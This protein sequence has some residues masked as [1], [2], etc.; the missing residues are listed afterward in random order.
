MNI[1]ELNIVEH[2]AYEFMKF[3]SIRKELMEYTSRP[4][5]DRYSPIYTFTTENLDSYL[6]VLNIKDRSCLTVTS[7][8]DQIINLALL[9]ASNIDCFDTNRVAYYFTK[10][11]LSALQ[12]LKYEEFIEYFTSLHAIRPNSSV[13]LLENNNVFSLSLYKKIYDY[14]DEDVKLFFDMIYSNNNQDNIEV[15]KLFYNISDER[16]IYNNT[17]LR[18]KEHYYKARELVKKIVDKGINYNTLDVF[19]IT[20]LKNKYDIVLLSNIYDYIDSKKELYADF[21]TQDV[22]NIVNQ[23]GDILVNYQYGYRQRKNLKIVDNL[24]VHVDAFDNKYFNV[25]DI[26]ELSNHKFKLIGVPSIYRN[27]RDEGI[28]DCVYIYKNCRTI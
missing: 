16:A 25:S 28:E 6:N 13:M 10:L 19:D 27:S 11:K 20:S 9:G 22:T 8:G 18:D 7:S 1:S 24:A 15:K 23:D 21:V 17:Y 2:D 3:N 26:R 4:L 12:A 5:F 14:L